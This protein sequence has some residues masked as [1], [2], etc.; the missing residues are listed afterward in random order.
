MKNVAIICEYNPFHYGHKLQIDE[1]RS[2][3]FPEQVCVISLMSGNFVERG[4]LACAQKYKRAEFAV[5][6]GSDLVLELPFPYPLSGAESYAYAA[7]KLL[8]ALPDIDYLC[9]GSESGR[10][11]Y[12]ELTAER[13][14]LDG[15][16]N[17]LEREVS[18]EYSISYA[19]LRESIYRRIYGEELPKTP[20]DILA[21]EYVKALKQLHSS[22]KPFIMKR[23][24]DFS[25][26][27]ARENILSGIGAKGLVPFDVSAYFDNNPALSFEDLKEYIIPYLMLSDPHELENYRGMNYDLAVKFVNSAKNCNS[28]AELEDRASD[29]R[30]S[31]ARVRRA[32]LSC[33]LKI[34]ESIPDAPGY[35]LL[36]AAGPVG[37]AYLASHGSK[38]LAIYSK[39][40]E[41][42]DPDT[43]NF[44]DIQ[45]T[46]DSLY[47][48]ILQ[49]K[50]VQVARKPFIVG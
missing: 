42:K 3:F 2:A 21:V 26:T 30:Y 25:A 20:N 15:F 4:D 22:I 14:L 32:L 8:T 45:T 46:A 36:L 40:S 33:A 23:E 29:K 41:I 5:N 43:L 9:F 19:A 49:I 7:V 18:S 37:K 6:N 11:E 1:I 34:K 44:Y 38:D 27:K 12:I 10:R 13:L 28:I 50:G 35:A 48:H 47:E 16:T 31:R 17:E 39:R 24:K